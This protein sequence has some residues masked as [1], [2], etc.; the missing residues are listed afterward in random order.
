MNC[1]VLFVAISA[2]LINS[3]YGIR[4]RTKINA[5]TMKAVT[6]KKAIAGSWNSVETYQQWIEAF[7]HDL[8]E[9]HRHAKQNTDSDG[10]Q[11]TDYRSPQCFPAK[12]KEKSLEPPESWPEI[13]W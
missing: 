8:R 9:T 11:Q 3:A 2:V 12:G 6:M 10:D 7:T 4:L 1:L 5:V 13:A